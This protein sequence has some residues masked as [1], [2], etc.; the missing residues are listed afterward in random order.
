M[1]VEKINRIHSTQGNIKTATTTLPSKS[2]SPEIKQNG[3]KLL[4]GSLAALA[5]AATISGVIY[6]RGKSKPIQK[7]NKETVD[8]IV[9]NIIKDMKFGSVKKGIAYSDEGI[10]FTGEVERLSKSGNKIV[11]RYEAGNIVERTYTIA[12]KQNEIAEINKL[13]SH[14]VEGIKMVDTKTTYKNGDVITTFEVFEK[15]KKF[16]DSIEQKISKADFDNNIDTKALAIYPHKEGS[17]STTWD[18]GDGL[19]LKETAVKNSVVRKLIQ[20]DEVIRRRIDTPLGKIIQFKNSDGNSIQIHE[21]L[22]FIQVKTST[23]DGTTKEY[24]GRNLEEMR[25]INKL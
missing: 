12:N 21:N 4:Y 20:N 11:T 15:N 14:E 18:L 7:L 10:L 19:I 16:V 2:N 1:P 23:P 17:V 6:N 8:E 9:D 13:Y 25:G 5:L 3:N 22:G 24:I